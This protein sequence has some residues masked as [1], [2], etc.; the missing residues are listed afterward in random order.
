MSNWA[1]PLCRW[2]VSF[3]TCFLCA[4]TRS[5]FSF[6]EN[7]ENYST[8][9][10]NIHAHNASNSFTHIHIIVSII[11]SVHAQV[12][13]SAESGPELDSCLSSNGLLFIGHL[14]M[15]IKMH[16]LKE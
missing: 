15:H 8:I 11:A 13:I 10:V 1:L 7:N 6:S 4:T 2:F 3:A 12:C 16:T 5:L 14:K 9:D